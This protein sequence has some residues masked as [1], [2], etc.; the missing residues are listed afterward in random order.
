MLV[1]IAYNEL[2]QRLERER[3][4]P[5]EASEEQRGQHLVKREE[6]VRQRSAAEA[7]VVCQ[8]H[9]DALC[10][11]LH[12]GVHVRVRDAQLIPAIALKE[13]VDEHERAEVRAH[14]AVFPEAFE[15][16]DGRGGDH[17]HHAQKVIE[18]LG[19]IIK[20]VLHAAP[21]APLGN[22]GL[23]VVT[24]ALTA[25]AVLRLPD[26]VKAFELFVYGSNK[27]VCDLHLHLPP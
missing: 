1:N 16:R 27:L 5:L 19:V 6:L 25:H 24:V 22:A 8:H 17:L 14:P 26:G 4:E 9:G 10:K 12:D 7:L 3:D 13:A 23:V 18:P 21:F 2:R 11:A 20:R 15:A